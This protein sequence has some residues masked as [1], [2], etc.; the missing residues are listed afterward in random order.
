MT[1][2]FRPLR[3]RLALTGFVATYAPV[4]VLLAVFF[5]TVETDSDEENTGDTVVVE[6]IDRVAVSMWMPITAL[7]LL[8]V[9]AGLSWWWAGRAVGPVERA[10]ANQQ[11]LIEETSH[12]LRTPLATLSANTDVLLAHPHPTVELYHQG[13]ERAGEQSRRITA[14]VEDL[15]VQARGRARTID[16][17]P[18][19][20]VTI[21]REAI[22]AIGPMAQANSVSVGLT[23]ARRAEA[24]VD[25]S[26]IERV[27]VN[28]LSNAVRHSPE[29]G[30]VDV[31]V[32]T[33][34]GTIEI[35][36]V[37]QGPGIPS[38]R[39]EQI[40]ERYW[41][42]GRRSGTG[43][44]L[45]IVMQVAEAHGGSVAVES[46]VDDDRGSRFILRVPSSIT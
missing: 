32:T 18:D 9:A 46:P 45:A 36:V 1:E 44:G 13:L 16:R 14:V 38:D 3:I 11:R 4:L 22:D 17:R 37:D 19:D 23:G 7:G 5:L 43:I 30:A 28:L 41:R 27:V 39:Q 15:L 31:A 20:M 2:L 21:V 29:G 40:F 35:S 6:S 42:Q 25:R 10:L 8:P 12:E 34:A 33:E 24:S 26:R